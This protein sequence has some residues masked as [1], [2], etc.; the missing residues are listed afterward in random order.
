MGLLLDGVRPLGGAGMHAGYRIDGLGPVQVSALA[1]DG[2][3]QATLRRVGRGTE[4]W[5]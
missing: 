5:R 1:L 2:R 4:N 3:V